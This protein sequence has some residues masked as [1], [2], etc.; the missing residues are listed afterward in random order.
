MSAISCC[1]LLRFVKYK[2]ALDS[3][4][5]APYLPYRKLSCKINLR[6]RR[7]SLIFKNFRQT[8]ERIQK[9][10][11]KISGIWIVPSLRPAS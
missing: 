6:D 2:L 5:Q 4:F 3:F 8:P 11:L 10:I 1:S 7:I 9:R